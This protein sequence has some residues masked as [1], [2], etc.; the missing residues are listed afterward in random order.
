MS[1]ISDAACNVRPS[2]RELHLFNVAVE[3][4]RQCGVT[5]KPDAVKVHFFR[6][7]DPHG[8]APG[9]CWWGGRPIEIGVAVDQ[10]D[11]EVVRT[12]LHEMKHAFDALCVGTTRYQQIPS[13]DR[14]R[15]CD[16][17]MTLAW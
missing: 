14:E 9:F 3:R 12:L 10:A 1:W 17:F 4:A 5:F 11:R 13:A 8:E 15:A 16:W 6:R 2:R 7:D